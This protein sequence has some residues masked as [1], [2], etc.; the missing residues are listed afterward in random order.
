MDLTTR[1]KYLREYFVVLAEGADE[2]TIR[3][4]IVTMPNYFD[5]YDTTVDF[6]SAE[7][8]KQDHQAMPHGG[9]VLRTGTT[10]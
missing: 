10:H 1:D 4:E 2:E 5:E 9:T 7:T 6:I 8:L 3:Q